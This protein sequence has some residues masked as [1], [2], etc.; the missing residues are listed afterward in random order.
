MQFDKQGVAY[1]IIDISEDHDAM[2]YVLGLGH[3]SAP[4]VVAGN[5]HWSGYRPE[6]IQAL[7]A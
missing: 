3:L 5:E 4:V 1:E 7:R 2:T 6:R